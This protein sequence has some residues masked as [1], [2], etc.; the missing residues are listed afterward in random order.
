MDNVLTFAAGV[1]ALFLAL[2]PLYCAW[3][4]ALNL[5]VMAAEQGFLGLAAFAACWFFLFPVMILGF[6]VIGLI[7]RWNYWF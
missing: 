2:Y 6:V 5:F 3:I 7:N 4:G 1:L